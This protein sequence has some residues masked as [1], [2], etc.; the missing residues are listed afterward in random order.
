MEQKEYK[1]RTGNIRRES[2]ET[3]DSDPIAPPRE[4]ELHFK[5]LF[6]FEKCANH[7]IIGFLES[8]SA[9]QPSTWFR[10]KQSGEL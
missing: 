10:Y 5:Q 2:Q 6:I 1:M 9:G 8:I 7:A 4:Y 3:K